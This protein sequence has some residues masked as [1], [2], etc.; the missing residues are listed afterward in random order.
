MHSA[1]RSAVRIL[2]DGASGTR[3][4]AFV[5]GATGAFQLAAPLGMGAV[6]FVVCPSVRMDTQSWLGSFPRV[7]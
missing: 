3:L 4:A 6:L 2:R 1:E 7:E 5:G